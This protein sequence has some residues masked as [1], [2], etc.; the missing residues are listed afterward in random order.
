[1][2]FIRDVRAACAQL[3]VHSCKNP[4]VPLLVGPTGVMGWFVA[5]IQLNPGEIRLCA[6]NAISE[7]TI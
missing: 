7:C 1:M 3:S 4:Q 2:H 6:Q 5:H